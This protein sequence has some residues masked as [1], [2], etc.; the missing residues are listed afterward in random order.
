MPTLFVFAHPRCTCTQATLKE[1]SRLKEKVGPQMAVKV[2]VSYDPQDAFDGQEIERQARSIANIEVQTD[3]NR[4]FAR[5][6]NALTSGQTVLYAP[7]G[8]LLFQGG[9][10]VSRGHEGV[11]PGAMQIEKIVTGPFIKTQFARTPTFGCHL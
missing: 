10:T 4:K 8:N 6:L 3:L 1:L 9:I 11:S 5:S 7:E 2:F